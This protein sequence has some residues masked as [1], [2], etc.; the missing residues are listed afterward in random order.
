MAVRL[1]G[2]IGL[3]LRRF[4][5]EFRYDSAAGEPTGIAGGHY[6]F[7]IWVNPDDVNV[8]REII[9]I[10]QRRS[11]APPLDAVAAIALRIEA[12]T[13]PG[14]GTLTVIL[15]GTALGTCVVRRSTAGALVA[16]AWQ[17]IEVVC[18]TSASDCHLY[19]DGVE[20]TYAFT[21]SD[22][23][24]PPSGGSDVLFGSTFRGL[25]GGPSYSTFARLV[26]GDPGNADPAKQFTTA[27]GTFF[28]GGIAHAGFWH[29]G[30]H[31]YGADMITA[32]AHGFAPTF[33][34]HRFEASSFSH[35]LLMAPAFY[36]DGEPLSGYNPEEEYDPVS[37]IKL[38]YTAGVGEA[39]WMAGPGVSE[40]C[41]PDLGGPGPPVARNPRLCLPFGLPTAGLYS[42][43]GNPADLLPIVYG[44]FRLGGLRGPVPA[45]L[46]DRG[47]DS[48]GPWVYCAAWHPIVS[49]DAVYID[50]VLQAPSTY[51]VNLSHS[52]QNRGPIATI[53]FTVQPTG[54]V[55]WR[56]RG[57]YDSTG[58]V[59]MENAI[60]Q[61]V[62]L[63]TTFGDFDYERDF[64]LTSLI[65]AQA[66]VTT[67]GYKTAFVI[68]DRAVTQEWLTEIL[69]NV[70]G[71]WRINGKEQ[72][73][74]HIDDGGDVPVSH[75]AA[76]I[77]AARDCRDG[78]DGVT[79]VLDK[80]AVVNALTAYYLY[81][82]SLGQA[83]SVLVS[84]RDLV[85]VNAYGEIRKAVTLRGLRRQV[86]V[87][88]WAS[89]LFDR[90]SART[91]VEGATVIFT[92]HGG[93]FAHLTIGDCIAFTWPYGP[94][95]ENGN[96]YINQILRIIEVALDG[97][98][99]GAFT[100]T[101]VDL[102][103]YVTEGGTRRLTPLPL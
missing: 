103:V 58:L 34:N 30:A 45:T 93:Q 68:L 32:L 42:N 82:W 95:R 17:R 19:V 14:A 89:I 53:T 4:T 5:P 97:T 72:V 57:A 48:L 86:D 36:G 79:F 29:E 98:R 73:E 28:K 3:M 90:Q 31:S 88:Q 21:R 24:L 13:G 35:G 23:I 70:M 83:S 50:D 51:T 60:D 62:H 99:G 6:R 55:S 27:P 77:V 47:T 2:T 87:E 43:P 59:V 22:A 18:L 102:G 10:I 54:P 41:P 80:Q 40:P 91:R 76:S 49:L 94:T 20:V 25:D 66:A 1:P 75:L 96:R 84:P 9:V 67:L 71:Y 85:S 16:G 12:T 33:F 100:I 44:D 8:Q 15:C 61:F 78:D 69:F 63:L 74:I 56:G 65:E 64:D 39:V 11:A 38:Q 101:A 7:G 46:I 37:G 52:F 26:N 92:V 81:A